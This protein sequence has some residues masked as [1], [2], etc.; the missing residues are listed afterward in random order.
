MLL[1]SLYLALALVVSFFCSISEAVMLSVRDSYVAALERD[2]P[3]PGTRALRELRGNLDRPLAAILTLNTIAH[4]VGAAG[5][6]AQAT[7][8]WGNEYLGW[9]SAV[10]T[11]LILVFSEIIPKTLGATH[12]KRL[13]STIGISVLWLT[14]AMRP[15]VWMSE[16]ITSLLSRSGTS[17]FTFSRAEMEAMA[18]IGVEEGQLD[19]RDMNIVRN[20]LRLD[21]LSVRDIMTPRTVI[22]SVPA[23]MSVGEFFEAH[24]RKP[25]SRIPLYEDSSD[26]VIGYVRKDDLFA[27]QAKDEFERPLSD[28]RRGFLAIPDQQPA[29]QAFDRL[30]REDA[31]IALVVD[32]YGS[33]QGLLTL[34]DALETLIGLEITDELDTVEDMQAF[35]RQRWRQRMQRMGMDPDQLEAA[36]AGGG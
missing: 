26:H 16:Q 2:G 4:T 35:A 17:A 5:V 29:S 33:V 31:H 22:F 1:L 7:R 13:A 14:R 6:G 10:L 23:D 24:S 11:L 36:P 30:T 18:R 8:I 9:T 21:R 28:F 25:F 20:L 15:F 12:W 34:E 3:T 19:V 32:E 27:A